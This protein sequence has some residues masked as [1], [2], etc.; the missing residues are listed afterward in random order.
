MKSI[1]DILNNYF[2]STPVDILER[3]WNELKGLN[4]WGPD[5][6]TYVENVL[7]ELDKEQLAN[8]DVSPILRTPYKGDDYYLAA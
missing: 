1:V 6:F 7:C 3:D 2:E 5:I 8:I 4:N